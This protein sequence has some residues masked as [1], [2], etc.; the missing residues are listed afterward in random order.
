MYVYI[1]VYMY[2]CIYVYMYM[3]MYM[4]IGLRICIYIY[5]Y[6]CVYLHIHMKLTTS[7]AG[8]RFGVWGIRAFR[9]LK[10]EL[11][12]LYRKQNHT[13]PLRIECLRSVEAGAVIPSL[14]YIQIQS[15]H[16]FLQCILDAPI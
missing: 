13:E 3:N 15:P 12:V 14:C 2:I 1:Y 8:T 7:T 10:P 9:S 4:Y 16:A 6:V 5:I 11:S